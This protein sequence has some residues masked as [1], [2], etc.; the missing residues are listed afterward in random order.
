MKQQI[1]MGKTESIM[2]W[3]DELSKHSKQECRTKLVATP[4]KDTDRSNSECEIINSVKV[5]ALNR[6][7]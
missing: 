7:K 6:K 1:C 5:K 3:T 4:D 2:T